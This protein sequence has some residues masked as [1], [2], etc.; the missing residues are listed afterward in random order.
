MLRRTVPVLILIIVAVCTVA[1][2]N[3]SSSTNTL[4]LQLKHK[5][6]QNS[7]KF[8][9]REDFSPWVQ[10]VKKPVGKDLEHDK[11]F[12]FLNSIYATVYFENNR[13]ITIYKM[14]MAKPSIYMASLF[15]GSADCQYNVYIQ[16]TRK[17]SIGYRQLLKPDGDT[18]PCWTVS[19]HLGTVL[20]HPAY[21]EYGNI[22]DISDSIFTR[23][24]PWQSRGW[25]QVCSLGVHF[26]NKLYIAHYFCGTNSSLCRTTRSLAIAVATRFVD[27]EKS[28]ENES[29]ARR[30]RAGF[31][32]NT[33]LPL[34]SY[35][36]GIKYYKFP[37]FG[38]AGDPNAGWDYSIGEQSVVFSIKVDNKGYIGVIGY[39]GVGWRSGNDILFAIYSRKPALKNKL[40]PLA[41]IAIYQKPESIKRID[42]NVGRNAIDRYRE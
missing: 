9:E 30:S 10:F 11:L 33:R 22:S 19:G 7:K 28:R 38:Y 31:Y 17:N 35:V 20:G 2:A 25:G 18:S 42:M 3:I 27:Y 39:N 13:D 4:C 41:S 23:I 32:F 26:T 21:I 12:K 24:T 8:I 16:K 40:I 6:D 15:Q 5:I 34:P 29:D 37:L 1:R 14:P 36:D